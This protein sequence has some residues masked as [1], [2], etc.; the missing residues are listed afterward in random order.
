[1][2]IKEQVV[3]VKWPPI[4]YLVFVL[5]VVN[6]SCQI[7]Q[8]KPIFSGQFLVTRGFNGQENENIIQKCSQ[9]IFTLPIY[10]I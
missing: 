1:M 3:P 9:I 4:I 10:L 7:L 6:F 2:K 8:C 5:K